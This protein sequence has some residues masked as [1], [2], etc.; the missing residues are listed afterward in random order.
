M[1]NW[2][3]DS[4]RSTLLWKLRRTWNR[5]WESFIIVSLSGC[6]I[7]TF[8]RVVVKLTVIPASQQIKQELSALSKKDHSQYDCCVVIMLSHGTEVRHVLDLYSLELPYT[9]WSYWKLLNGFYPATPDLSLFPLPVLRCSWL[10]RSNV[11]SYIYSQVSH[12]RFPGAVYGVDGLHVP[13][14]LITNYLNGQNCPSLQ[15]K[16]KLFFIQACGGGS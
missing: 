1:I 5:K 6:N 11:F 14:Q 3:A 8:E 12:S 9:V 10:M 7:L 13:V 16:P 4:G 15:S 2:S